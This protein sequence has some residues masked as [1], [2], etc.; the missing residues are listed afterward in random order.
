MRRRPLAL[1]ARGVQYEDAGKGA[2]LNP[3]IDFICVDSG[4]G[5]RAAANALLDVIRGQ[6][7][8]WDIRLLSIQDLLHPIDFIRKSTGVE[9]QE[10]YNIIL[11]HG[12]TIVTPSLV[13]VAHTLIRLSH[14]AQVRILEEH[15]KAD[16][17]DMVVSLIP[18]Y[19]RSMFQA[20]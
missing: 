1:P 13:P 2:Q 4:G 19:N 18:H 8:P 9:F 15:W 3:K 7:R 6:N 16:P 12:W 10:V 17:P 20:F 5:P 11:R 14:A